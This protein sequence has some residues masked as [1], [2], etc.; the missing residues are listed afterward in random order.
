MDQAKPILSAKLTGDVLAVAIEG[1]L[2]SNQ[3]IEYILNKEVDEVLNNAS[4][5]VW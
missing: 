3:K 5:K 2:A 1:T 4:L